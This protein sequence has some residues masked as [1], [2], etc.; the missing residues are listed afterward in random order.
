[1]NQLDHDHI[2]AQIAHLIA[3]TARIN[4]QS[5]KYNKELRWY[6]VTLIIAGTIA[7]TGFI[8]LMTKVLL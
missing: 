8:A 3:D 2:S 4:L 7:A 5:Q 6:E 1:M